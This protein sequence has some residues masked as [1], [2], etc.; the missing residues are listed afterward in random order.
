MFDD[1]LERVALVPG[2]VIQPEPTIERVYFVETGMVSMVGVVDEDNLFE[3]YGVGYGGK[4]GPA[5]YAPMAP[6]A[7]GPRPD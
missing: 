5:P 6:P 4:V 3:V 2:Q 7:P 1:A